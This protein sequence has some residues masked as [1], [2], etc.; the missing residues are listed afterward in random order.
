[1]HHK[2]NT[3]FHSGSSCCSWLSKF[4]CRLLALAEWIAGQGLVT[5]L[6]VHNQQVTGCSFSFMWNTEPQSIFLLVC[7]LTTTLTCV[8]IPQ[9]WVFFGVLAV[10]LYGKQPD[11]NQ[12]LDILD[13]FNENARDW[14]YSDTLLTLSVSAAFISCWQ[15]QNKTAKNKWGDCN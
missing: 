1:M 10:W 8:F 14:T 3:A 13:L 4:R 9:F 2:I 12:R 11:W 5:Q 6:I 15:I 7:E